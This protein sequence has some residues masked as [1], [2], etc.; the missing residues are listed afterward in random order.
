MVNNEFIKC[1]VCNTITRVRLQ[2]GYLKHHPIF[3]TCGGCGITM[4]GIVDIDQVNIKLAFTFENA[5]L[6]TPS[7]V[8]R[9]YDYVV[10]CS[11]EL[12]TKKMREDKAP[13]EN[14]Y[15]T[16]YNGT[17]FLRFLERYDYPTF[18]GLSK[19]LDSSVDKW[20]STKRIFELFYMNRDNLLCQELSKFPETESSHYEAS[21]KHSLLLGVN[22]LASN[23]LYKPLVPD[24]VISPYKYDFLCIRDENKIH[25]FINYLNSTVGLDLNTL[26]K[27]IFNITNDFIDVWQYLIPAFSLSFIKEG[28]TFDYEE[29]GTTASSFDQINDFY[30]DAYETLGDLLI[31]PV[32][33]DNIFYRNNYNECLLI[34]GRT[35]D[36]NEF[37]HMKK[38]RKFKEVNR[39][40]KYVSNTD[41]HVEPDMRNAINHNDYTYDSVSQ[42]VTY[43]PN[44]QDVTISHTRYLLNIEEEIIS[45]Y[46]SI[47]IISEY[48]YYLRKANLTNQGFSDT[49]AYNTGIITCGRN[50][51]CPC[52]SGFKYKFCHGRVL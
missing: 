5:S 37:N 36:I 3:V 10:E 11:G 45:I 20:S 12:P 31:I 44:P 9:L 8:E 18:L 49:H 24:I 28:E 25:D 21:D 4:R 14:P 42:I 1:Q 27:K 26:G 51:N 38:G 16:S 48:L 34:S 29:E 17:P 19:I 39:N 30:A 33:L 13:H 7:E 41:L 32:G 43:H 50:E 40:E 46:K 52:G 15:S 22:K 6:E 2:V 35:C 23:L 47:L